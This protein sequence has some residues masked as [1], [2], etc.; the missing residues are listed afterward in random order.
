MLVLPPLKAENIFDPMVTIG[1]AVLVFFGSIFFA[2]LLLALI[3]LPPPALGPGDPVAQLARDPAAAYYLVSHLMVQATLGA[4]VLYGLVKAKAQSGVDQAL[5]LHRLP[6][7][8]VWPWIAGGA[9]CSLLVNLLSPVLRGGFGI[10]PSAD[11]LAAVEISIVFL[12]AAVVAAPVFEELLFRGFVLQS[13][14][15]TRIGVVGASLATTLAWTLLHSHLDPVQAFFIF[16]LGLFLCY[17]RAVTGSLLVPI[18]MHMA[19]NGTS[20]L[21]AA[22]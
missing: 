2:S 9:G 12:A 22:M 15:E 4:A 21:I 17:A 1:V 11:P 6:A 8:V 13:L 14:A 20:V 3:G 19:F 18:G 16:G 10:E 5:A 7:P